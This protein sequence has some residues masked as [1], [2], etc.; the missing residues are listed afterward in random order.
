MVNYGAAFRLPFTNWRRLL[1]L[2]ALS[3]AVLLVPLA[4][5]GRL[6]INIFR[7]PAVP[8]L[9]LSGLEWAAIGLA[10]V[11]AFVLGLISFGYIIRVAGYAAEGRN[12]MPPFENVSG[13]LA[14]ALKYAMAAV[15]YTLLITLP[16]V[17]VFGVLALPIGLFKV[18]PVLLITI[19]TFAWLIFSIYAVPM[20]ITHFSH[21]KRFAA[22]FAFG[23][24][25]KYSFT[26][27]YFVPWIVAFGYAYGLG[28][29]AY[30]VAYFSIIASVVAASFSGQFT[31][32]IVAVGLFVLVMYV[33]IYQIIYVTSFSLYGQAYHDITS[34]K[35]ASVAGKAKLPKPRK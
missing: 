35:A 31:A 24:A 3:S 27:A 13:M 33:F 18:M 19:W 8:Q 14:S 5:T 2:W 20:L 17:I 32:G 29:L 10:I 6:L 34:S 23:R 26:T 16:Y 7:L 22:L 25:V 21:N 28:T 11:A 1:V 12:V 15:A 30:M 9:S 4:A